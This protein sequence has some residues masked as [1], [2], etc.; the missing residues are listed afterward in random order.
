[1]LLNFMEKTFSYLEEDDKDGKDDKRKIY[2][3]P[4]ILSQVSSFKANG[5]MVRTG[6]RRMKLSRKEDEGKQEYRG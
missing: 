2:L 4:V 5:E 3:I 6:R 1:M